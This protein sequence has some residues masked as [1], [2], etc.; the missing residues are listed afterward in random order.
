MPAN[1]FLYAGFA[2][3]SIVANSYANQQLA[4]IIDPDVYFSGSDDIN[5]P[6]ECSQH[7]WAHRVHVGGDDTC[8]AP[9][10]TLERN[11]SPKDS[12]VDVE[13]QLAMRK[14]AQGDDLFE[15]VLTERSISDDAL[16]QAAQLVKDDLVTLYPDV[17]I[18]VKAQNNGRSL[19]IPLAHHVSKMTIEAMQSSGTNLQSFP[20]FRELMIALLNGRV[21]PSIATF[22]AM[23]TPTYVHI[24]THGFLDVELVDALAASYVLPKP[25]MRKDNSAGV[26]VVHLLFRDSES[27]I[28]DMLL[29]IQHVLQNHALKSVDELVDFM[30]K[31]Q[32]T[33]QLSFY[34]RGLVPVSSSFSTVLDKLI[35]SP[36]SETIERSQVLR[37]QDE[38]TVHYIEQ[39]LQVP[40]GFDFGE[41]AIA[42][43]TNH[44]SVLHMAARQNMPRSLAT[45][46]GI[47]RRVYQG[48]KLQDF[49]V[50][51]LAGMEAWV[52]RTPLH[53]AAFHHGLESQIYKDLLALT[54]EFP[55]KNGAESWRDVLS[56]TPMDLGRPL[57][58]DAKYSNARG[59]RPRQHAYT[60]E[61]SGD[62]GVQTDQSLQKDTELCE[63][64]E[65]RG[66][67]TEAHHLS[68]LLLRPDPSV[69][70]AA[71]RPSDLQSFRFQEVQSAM[72]QLDPSTPSVNIYSSHADSSVRHKITDEL[73]QTF[74]CFVAPS[75]AESQNYFHSIVST[76]PGMGVND[77][78]ATCVGLAGAKSPVTWSDLIMLDTLAFGRRH[79]TIWSPAAMNGST[80]RQV[81]QEP[82]DIIVIPKG[83]AFQVQQLESGVSSVL[84]LRYSPSTPRVWDSKAL[85][86]PSLKAG[87][88]DR[89]PQQRG[90]GAI[91]SF[92]DQQYQGWYGANEEAGNLAV[93]GA[94][95]GRTGTSTMKQ[96]LEELGF[97]RCYHMLENVNMNHTRL[98]NSS[99]QLPQLKRIL[100]EGSYRSGVDYPFCLYYKEW[101]EM[102][103]DAKIVLTVRSN[104]S[105]WWRSTRKTLYKPS[106]RW[107][108]LVSRLLT[109]PDAGQNEL[110]MWER[111]LLWEGLYQGNFLDEVG[112]LACAR[113]ELVLVLTTDLL[114]LKDHTTKVFNNHVRE[115]QEYAAKLGRPVLVYRVDAGEGWKP[116]CDFLGVPVPNRLR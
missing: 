19:K 35:V 69:V 15:K 30:A 105:K 7:H 56:Q 85:K 62:W 89:I 112:A 18:D 53:F 77:P 104:V 58:S 83:W 8:T 84:K 81:T 114:L 60:V 91:Q 40:S 47:L 86:D 67:V 37:I 3:C 102:F 9:W 52:Y 73:K 74:S 99:M 28:K 45:V 54:T 96:V 59:G 116:L 111:Q 88:I 79:W 82:G 92:M 115:V 38:L 27:D 108:P 51:L 107:F 72:A 42:T 106:S 75:L 76:V 21:S 32:E 49:M 94:G 2:L 93:I 6:Y 22:N 68:P 46:I 66:L 113:A 55:Q 31:S 5:P 12:P 103:P 25:F 13:K 24:L 39:W 50:Y 34:V 65:L 17:L 109:A 23:D 4:P 48:K 97:G 110:F 78:S 64:A 100:K 33:L 44:F 26:S 61:E 43:P 41:W 1:S 14:F 98:W 63:V 101:M 11:W 10:K 70:R 16:K 57:G 71:V 87:K 29:G 36:A 80:P 90:Q 95:F 20:H